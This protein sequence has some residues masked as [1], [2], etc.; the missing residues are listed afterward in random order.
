MKAMVKNGVIVPQNHFCTNCGG[1]EYTVEKVEHINF[2]D[3]NFAALVKTEV[4]QIERYS[5][6]KCWEEERS[7]VQPKLLVQYL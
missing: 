3:I 2:I 1:E 6:V 4:E 5:T 7:N